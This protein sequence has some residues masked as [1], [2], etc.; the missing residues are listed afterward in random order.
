MPAPRPPKPDVDPAD[1]PLQPV[2]S[3]AFWSMMVLAA[4]CLAGAS[5]VAL[6]GPRLFVTQPAPAHAAGGAL[7]G[8]A[9]ER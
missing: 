1:K 9:K 7:G 5:L 3:A 8:T 2:L 6:E 4:A